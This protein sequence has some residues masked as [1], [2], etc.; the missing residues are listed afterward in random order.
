MSYSQ[1]SKYT[2]LSATYI[3][4]II[5]E[6]EKKIASTK[7]KAFCKWKNI[8]GIQLSYFFSEKTLEE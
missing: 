1:I 3:S 2:G 7:E 6:H 4:K 8:N 5:A